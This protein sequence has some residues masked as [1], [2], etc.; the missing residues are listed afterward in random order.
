MATEIEILAGPAGAG[1]TAQLLALYRDALVAGR[2]SQT[3]GRTLWLSPTLRVC[4]QVRRRLIG[5]QLPAVL[6]PQ[7]LT[8]DGFADRLLEFS[9]DVMRPLPAVMQRVLAR[10]IVASQLAEGRIQY[11]AGIARTSGFLDVVLGLVAELKREEAWP[12]DFEL[13]CQ[14]RGTRRADQELAGIYREYQDILHRHQRYDSEGRFWSA[15][16]RLGKNDWRPF[17]SFD[18]V[19]VDGFSDF[20]HTQYEILE[21]LARRAERMAVSLPLEEPLHRSDLFAKPAVALSRLQT[22]SDCRVKSMPKQFKA[23]SFNAASEKVATL[24]WT[25]AHISSKLFSNPRNLERAPLAPGLEVLAVTGMTGEVRAVAERVKALLVNGTPAVEIVVAFR[26][27]HAYAPLVRE[28]FLNAGIPV[29]CDS[30]EAL[31]HQPVIKAL[32]S[33]VQLELEDWPFD[34]LLAVLNSGWF[35]PAWAEWDSEWIPRQV[36]RILRQA[37]IPEGR[38]VILDALRKAA[39]R[40]AEASTDHGGAT[41]PEESTERTEDMVDPSLLANAATCLE[42]LSDSLV[43]IRQKTDARTWAECLTKLARELGIVATSEQ[44]DGPETKAAWQAFENLLFLAAGTEELLDSPRQRLE[45]AE[46]TQSLTDLLQHQTLAL[47]RRGEGHVEVVD[48]AQVRGLDVPYLFLG[49]LTEDS[50]PARGGDSFLYNEAD[51]QEL[52]K[53]GLTLGQRSAQTQAEMLLFYSIVTRARR[54]LILSYPAVTL[55]GQPLSPSPYLTT[56]MDLFEP[57]AVKFTRLEQLDPVPAI[58]GMLSPA[59]L[60][61]VAT[62]EAL[63][64]RTGLFQTLHE[65]P[66]GWQ[67]V[68]SILAAIEMSIHRFQTRG[69]TEYEGTIMQAANL[70]SLQEKYAPRLEFSATQLE[71]YAQCPFRFFVSDVLHV[72]E[73]EA[74]DRFT[75]HGR[76]GDIVHEVLAE[77]HTQLEPDVDSIPVAETVELF[78]KLL[79]ERLSR[80]LAGTELLAALLRIE[81]RLLDEW[82]QEYAQ[83]WSDYYEQ[84]LKHA[85]TSLKPT[86]L[87]V[88]FGRPHSTSAEI[89]VETHPCLTIGQGGDETRIR[90]RIDRIDTGRREGQVVFNVID[91]KTGR[92]PAT[93]G[94]QVK[95]G[96]SLQLVLYALAVQRLNL[97]GENS[98]PIQAGYWCLKETGWAPLTKPPQAGPQG[99]VSHADWAALVDVLDEL[100]P[101]LAAGIRAGRFP[102]YNS[103][104][105]CTSY[106]AYKTTCRVNQIRPLEEALDKH[107]EP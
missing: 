99:L 3:P 59:D 69:F 67:T 43:P 19:V 85:G 17:T 44:A 12:E 38:T 9:T 25:M 39:V 103:E 8:F 26:P 35:R 92:K 13:A 73:G 51:R 41:H 24:E 34:R 100:V 60:R 83:Q 53:H 49:G 75:D 82:G 101:R 98:F 96:R 30:P 52:N 71:R 6:A 1:K 80:E 28:V 40:Q 76:R 5:P 65:Q 16:D 27:L 58:H 107:W 94:S 31:H 42:R 105:E 46:Y 70:R 14:K 32:L 29:Q 50:F 77:L 74:P 68:R 23:E 62:S 20:T 45:L 33:V 57:G 88:S 54:Q 15:R 97:V 90:G 2:V 84:V 63:Q 10:R 79:E 72:Q 56:L 86:L 102:V 36:S 87:E 78:R 7:V 4:E 106:C 37:K 89:E 22:V 21:M 18:L 104:T 11:Y 91:Y 48:A 81:Q 93:S 66:R 47:P 55:D 64:R 95:S 61:L